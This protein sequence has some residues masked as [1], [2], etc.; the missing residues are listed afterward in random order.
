MSALHRRGLQ[1]TLSTSL[2]LSGTSHPTT[3]GISR[4]GQ[5][6][7]VIPAEFSAAENHRR[8][9]SAQPSLDVSPVP[10]LRLAGPPRDFSTLHFPTTDSRSQHVALPLTHRHLSLTSEV[11]ESSHQSLPLMGNSHSHAV[12]TPALRVSDSN[13]PPILFASTSLYLQGMLNQESCGELSSTTLFLLTPFKA[14]QAHGQPT[15]WQS[16]RQSPKPRHLSQEIAISFLST[17]LSPC[18]QLE[19]GSLVTRQTHHGTGRQSDTAPASHG[20]CVLFMDPDPIATHTVQEWGWGRGCDWKTAKPTQTSHRLRM[21]LLRARCNPR[22]GAP[23][24]MPG[25]S[26]GRNAGGRGRLFV[27]LPGRSCLLCR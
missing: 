6:S 15:P 19:F 5:R 22:L 8:A 14:T 1:Q 4:R 21:Q 13:K 12:S 17:A 23:A 26:L 25:S 11:H 27:G 3:T 18:C 9:G 2:Q 10:C 16:R 24:A 7:E 20:C